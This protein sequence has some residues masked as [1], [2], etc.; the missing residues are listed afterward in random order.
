MLHLNRHLFKP[1]VQLCNL[2]ISEPIQHEGKK[3]V[4]SMKTKLN[5][6]ERLNKGKKLSQ[7][8]ELSVVLHQNIG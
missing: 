4:V 5:I 3:E 8:V 1:V 6:L 2:N 7:I